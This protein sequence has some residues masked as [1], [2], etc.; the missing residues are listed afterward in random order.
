MLRKKCFI[1][2]NNG[3]KRMPEVLRFEKIIN[4]NIFQNDFSDMSSNANAAIEFR[5]NK[6][7]SGGIAVIY[8]PNGTGKTSLAKVL[9]CE[10]SD[11]EKIFIASYNDEN[12]GI[13]EQKFYVINDQLSRNVIKGDTSDYLIGANIR[14]EYELKKKIADEFIYIF[15]VYLP[16]KFKNDFK[17]TKIGDY[18]IGNLGDIQAQDY[19]KKI[20]NAKNRGKDINQKEFINY[21]KGA[22]RREIAEE[23]EEA[24]LKFFI[25]DCSGAKLIDKIFNIELATIIC[26]SKVTTLEQKDDAITIL[27]KYPHLHTCIVCDNEDFN[28]QDLLDSKKTSRKEI[29]E[30]L[31]EKTKKILEEI[32]NDKSLKNED[33]YNIKRSVLK[34][35]SD[36]EIQEFE[37]LKQELENYLQIAKNKILNTLF[38]CLDESSLISDFEEYNGLIAGQPEIDDEDLLYI[39]TIISDNIDREIEIKRDE[40]ND[41]NFMI[42]LSNEQFLG[43]DR[44]DLHLSTGE[45]NFISLAFELLIAR[46][47]D[48]EFIVLD[49]PISSF[50]SLYKNKIAYCII[51]FLEN[52]K[53][54]IFTHNTDLI[55]LLEAQQQGCFNLYLFNNTDSGKNGFIR[56][57]DNEKDILLNM[58]KLIELFQNKENKLTPYIKNEHLF[59]ASMIP[60]MRGYANLLK[61]GTE[62]YTTLS[63]IMHG[64]E[65]G[66]VDIIDIYNKLFGFKFS[67]TYVLSIQDLLALDVSDIE[68]ID[69]EQ[70]PLLSETLRQT[71]IY[72]YLR[73]RVESELV[74]KFNIRR[75]QNWKLH[76]I[77]FKSFCDK[78]EDTIEQKKRNRN[79]RV[80]F[81]SRKTL[82]NEFNHFEG[83]MNIFQPAID[84]KSE[85]LQKEV[86]SILDM[87]EEVK[88]KY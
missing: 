29:Y 72:Y 50:D 46:R 15:N 33:P 40:Q 55:K 61:D 16:P 25:T 75:D 70:F 44:T 22:V 48:R 35:I 83:N 23:V 62:V 39:K 54:L 51:K 20:V 13:E 12:F 32:I 24:K 17:I 8:G 6:N 2:Q 73:M 41:N 76:H 82:L 26:N 67:N 60:F 59:L 57:K 49:D 56:V 69:T 34:F 36:G 9:E 37:E 86:N 77:I 64:Y 43:V 5:E 52:K 11:N 79:Y 4:G 14:R 18:L 71:L 66:S 10:E 1:I 78:P 21:I 63:S 3:G 84:I 31:D 38:E 7:C 65:N 80:F 88:I 87:L 42:L 28:Y 74:T 45:Q 30:N 47:T 68:I 53:Q 58:H 81:T 27:E 19:I 85:A